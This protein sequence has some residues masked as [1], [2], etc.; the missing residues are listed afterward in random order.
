MRPCWLRGL[1]P[2][3]RRPHR[4]ADDPSGPRAESGRRGVRHAGRGSGKDPP[5]SARGLDF[6][7]VRR[8]LP[9]S[10][11]R[12]RSSP[13]TSCPCRKP[14]AVAAFQLAT[15]RRRTCTRFCPDRSRRSWTSASCN[16]CRPSETPRPAG[17]RTRGT[18]VI[19]HPVLEHRGDRL[20]LGEAER[21]LRRATDPTWLIEGSRIGRATSEDM[22]IA[23]GTSRIETAYAL[24]M[25]PSR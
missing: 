21:P 3:G 19:D 7:R 1:R 12:S 9:R 15:L 4:P 17:A 23:A 10:S 18:P 16:G 5:L 6:P 24:S 11:R 8:A 25:Y 2:A 14:L 13:S 22:S 20:M